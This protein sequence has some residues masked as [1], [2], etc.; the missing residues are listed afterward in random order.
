[1][2][3]G[4]DQT[5]P[6]VQRRYDT[7]LSLAV[8]ITPMVKCYCKKTNVIPRSEAP[9]NLGWGRSTRPQIPPYGRNDSCLRVT[10]YHNYL[11]VVLAQASDLVGPCLIGPQAAKLGGHD[12]IVGHRLG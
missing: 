7:A 11:E 6:V 1:M 3:K 9:R 10:D 5:T 12:L 8:S 4:V 2:E